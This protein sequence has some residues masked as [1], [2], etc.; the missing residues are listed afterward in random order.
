MT[1]TAEQSESTH[2]QLLRIN[3]TF[4]S[5]SYPSSIIPLYE[6]M[7]DVTSIGCAYGVGSLAT[8][9]PKNYDQGGE[10]ISPSEEQS[11]PSNG[12]IGRTREKDHILTAQN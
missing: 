7:D 6:N 4:Y 9:T 5:P 11:S 1:E 8:L 2:S 3:P 12:R 10:I